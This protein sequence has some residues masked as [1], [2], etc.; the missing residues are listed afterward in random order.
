MPGSDQLTL[1]HAGA[2]WTSFRGRWSE[3]GFATFPACRHTPRMIFT[4]RRLFLS[5]CRATAR[6]VRTL[7]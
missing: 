2:Y 7:V 3:I 6:N 1:V 5:E 4:H